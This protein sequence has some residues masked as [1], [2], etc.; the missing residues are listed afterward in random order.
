MIM[1]HFAPRPVRTAWK[2]NVN[3]I[4]ARSIASS[5][6]SA[7]PPRERTIGKSHRERDERG[8]DEP[9]RLPAEEEVQC[10]H[11]HGKLAQRAA[12]GKRAQERAAKLRIGRPAARALRLRVGI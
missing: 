7:G 1:T 10:A 8:A 2:A 5:R 6:M 9:A 4:T 3:W 12:D 11:G